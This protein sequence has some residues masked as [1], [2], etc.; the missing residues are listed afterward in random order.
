MVREALRRDTRDGREGDE[1]R[2]EEFREGYEGGG[3]EVLVVVPP[4]M[5][6]GILS[7]V[8]RDGEGA[9]I[10]SKEDVRIVAVRRQGETVGGVYRRIFGN[11]AGH[12]PGGRDQGRSG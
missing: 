7:I 8:V 1:H 5:G 2:G 6:M 11:D 4:A 12:E 9:G 3:R 10:I